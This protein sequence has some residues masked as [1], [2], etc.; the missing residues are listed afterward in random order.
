MFDFAIIGIGTC[1]VVA[2]WL[3]A[4]ETY[5]RSNEPNVVADDVDTGFTLEHYSFFNLPYAYKNVALVGDKC[6]GYTRFI[7]GTSFSRFHV[8]FSYFSYMLVIS[9][10]VVFLTHK[11][12]CYRKR[13]FSHVDC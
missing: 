3:P 7:S 1:L 8:N 5:K 4:N 11:M 9:M 12:L 13:M 10:F 6:R 2:I